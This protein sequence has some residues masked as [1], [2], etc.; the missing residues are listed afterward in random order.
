M[1]GR[2]DWDAEIARAIAD[3]ETIADLAAR[4]GRAESTARGAAR[5]RGVILPDAPRANAALRA[6]WADIDELPIGKEISVAAAAAKF[7]NALNEHN[8]VTIAEIEAIGLV[9][10]KTILKHIR[11]G[12][13]KG[14]KHDVDGKWMWLFEPADV[15]A[16]LATAA[17]IVRESIARRG[18]RWTNE[19]PPGWLTIAE[20][21]DKAKVSHW[22]VRNAIRAGR[23]RWRPGQRGAKLVSVADAAAFAKEVEGLCRRPIEPKPR[24]VTQPPR[25]GELFIANFDV[26]F[27]LLISQPDLDPVEL[28][29]ACGC[30]TETARRWLALEREPSAI[31]RPAVAAFFR[32][33]YRATLAA[34]L[35]TKE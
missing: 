21:A 9:S 20:T 31:Y 13:L 28:A 5:R 27:A 6:L 8:L 26:L 11:A 34:E 15:E 16:Y 24:P 7:A 22:T 30:K 4:V 10:R 35:L 2:V 12:L 3:R 19:A 25:P 14:D 23:L 29:A 1:S 18:E 32:A 33:R 17:N